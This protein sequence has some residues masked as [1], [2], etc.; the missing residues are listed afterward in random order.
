MVGF[1]NPN[2]NNDAPKEQESQ[3][4]NAMSM[5]GG[6]LTKMKDKVSSNI[7]GQSATSSTNDPNTNTYRAPNMNVPQMGSFGSGNVQ[8]R[9]GTQSDYSRP[10]PNSGSGGGSTSTSTGEY[11]ARFVSDFC[12][13]GG[14]RV[15]PTAPALEDFCRKAESL[16]AQQMA[17]QLRTKLEDQAWQT[18]LKALYAIEALQEKGLDGIVG[19]ILN[20]STEL[21]FECQ[22]MPQLKSKATKV[23]SL[24][25][26]IEESAA[27]APQPRAEPTP[28][29][30][31]GPVQAPPVATFDLLSMDD[32]GP[33]A[34]PSAQSAPPP[35]ITADSLLG[36]APSLL[37]DDMLGAAPV[38]EPVAPSTGG[39]GGGG[40]FG[41]LSVAGPSSEAAN[42]STTA[43]TPPQVSQ[44]PS[45]LDGLNQAAPAPA[46]APDAGLGGMFSNLSIGGS[47]GAAPPQPT[48]AAASA[49]APSPAA[50][51]PDLMGGLLGNAAPSQGSDQ[52]NRAQHLSFLSG[53]MGMG[54]TG[55]G[56]QGAMGGMG[57]GNMG[58]MQGPAGMG[59]P[60]MG[61]A[62]GGN[63][64]GGAMGVGRGMMPGM[65]GPM[66]GMMGGQ[67]G[68][69]M[70]MG[71][72]AMGG[73]MMGN[74]MGMMNPQM[75]Q[76][77]MMAPQMMQQQGAM[78]GGYGGP[79]GMTPGGPSLGGPAGG[80]AFGFIGG[81]GAPAQGGGDVFAAAAPA[82]ANGN[83]SAFSF[84]VDEIKGAS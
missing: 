79:A 51:S 30:A 20:F 10:T 81:G 1:G 83:D 62:M 76:Q 54:P 53:G 42:N 34:A 43:Y 31:P 13:P 23:L 37:G 45:L 72:G 80:S 28:A 47:D 6:Y 19:H 67:M 64:M 71:P 68:G 27:A 46:P 39:G 78:M 11:E 26:L 7:T 9:W 18:R 70:G 82:P 5:A 65:G 63:P 15:A 57:P 4:K 77:G 17:R 44:G 22:E 41:G 56:M 35:A 38:A 29:P 33:S 74:S 66:G 50:A 58:G 61:M 73:P 8:G 84:V 48:T 55:G 69:Q 21:L 14:P 16:D 32:D 36:E 52:A 12:A 2:F 60:G 24:L 59:N 40:L 75:M 49:P 3:L 25:G